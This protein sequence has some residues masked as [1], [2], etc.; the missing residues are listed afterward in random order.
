M[1]GINYSGT[2]CCRKIISLR[3]VTSLGV[4][5]LPQHTEVFHM[6][7]SVLFV[8]SV[9]KQ[10]I[11]HTVRD[12]QTCRQCFVAS[13]SGTPTLINTQGHSHD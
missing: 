8:H 7:L 2:R 10:A 5:L 12:T 4:T 3:V 11:K 6:A 1:S 9:R 13:T